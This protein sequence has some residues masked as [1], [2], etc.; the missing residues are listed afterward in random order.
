M[1]SSPSA[2]SGRVAV[3][4]GA[5][6]GIG[7]AVACR[8]AAE[9][10]AVVLADL[11]R[12][13]VESAAQSIGPKAR[14]Y[15]LD[16]TDPAQVDALVADVL[17]HEGHVDVLVNNAG[18]AG[19]SAP[20]A[21]YPLEEWRRILAL[22]IDAVFYCTRALLPH[23]VD[24]EAGRIVNLASVAGKE[25]NPNMAAYSTSKA[26]VIGFTKAVAREVAR[27]GVLVNCVTPAVI[28]TGLLEQLSP[29]TLAGLVEKIPM[30]RTGQ[31]EEVA[32]LVA[33]LASPRCSF[34]TGAAFDISGGRA[35]Y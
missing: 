6:G 32:E 21:E 2:E 18:I 9:G 17:A 29:E 7:F 28:Q 23:L 10:L 14:P 15:A 16:L 13:A 34:S 30:G 35:T 24:R 8:L 1:P 4:T 5:A 27:T 20:T 3:V 31:P 11:D 26:A 33:W 25:G 22:N 19:L 12:S